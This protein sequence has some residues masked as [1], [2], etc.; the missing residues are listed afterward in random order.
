MG[1]AAKMT[2]KLALIALLAITCSLQACINANKIAMDVGQPPKGAVELRSLQTRRFDT[3]DE[4]KM[5]SAATQ[6]LQDL[7]FIVS[8]SQVDV[9]VLVGSKKRDAEEA[10]QVAGQVVMTIAFA[11]LGVYHKPLWDKEQNIVV[12]IVTTPIANSKQIEIRASFD[13]Q[14]TNNQGHQWRAELLMDPKL[15]QEFFAKIAEGVFLEAH[16]I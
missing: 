4:M 1:K 9:G 6:T 16:T 14:L 5:I 15:Y 12:T 11:V 7:G 13:R 8:E 2:R 3:L 10:G